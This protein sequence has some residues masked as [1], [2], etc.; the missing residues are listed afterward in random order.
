[1]GGQAYQ[2]GPSTSALAG[3]HAAHQVVPLTDGAIVRT[4]PSTKPAIRPPVWAVEVRVGSQRFGSGD[5]WNRDGGPWLPTFK[6]VAKAGCNGTWRG[7][8]WE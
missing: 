4:L 8:V 5:G 1:M 6:D 2:S 7:P 3:V